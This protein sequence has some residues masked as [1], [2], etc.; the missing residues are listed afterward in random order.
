MDEQPEIIFREK[1]KF[2]AWIHLMVFTMLFFPVAIFLFAY[3]SE[4]PKKFPLE[5]IDILPIILD[6][7][8]PIVVEI[9]FLILKLETEVRN[10]GVYVRLFPAHIKYRKFTPEEISEAFARKYQPVAEYRG[11]GI[12]GSRSNRAYN[13]RGNEGVQLVF[14]NGKK[15][16]IGSQK[17]KE[18]ENA[19]KS[20]L[21][22]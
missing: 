16:L 5:P 22:N 20:I 2:G 3:T 19:I 12:K 6:T 13:T 17:A 7:S 9:I 14:K 15:L 4:S 18:L 1:Q 11:W 8:I 10:D 21:G